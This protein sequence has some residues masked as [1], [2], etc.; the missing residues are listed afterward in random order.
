MLET[1]AIVEHLRKA[2]DSYESEGRLS[3]VKPF[4]GDSE[5]GD[6]P[7]HRAL[8][9]AFSYQFSLIQFT[10]ALLSVGIELEALEK[11]RRRFVW[12]RPVLHRIRF[13][14]GTGEYDEED[15]VETTSN[16]RNPDYVDVGKP[17]VLQHLARQT[18]DAFSWLRSESFLFALKAALVIAVSAIPSL[19]P[20]SAYFFYTNRGIWSVIVI[21][22]TL[23][24]YAGDTLF[25]VL[26]RIRGNLFGAVAGLIVWSIVS[27]TGIPHPA[28]LGFIT[29]ISFPLLLFYRIYALPA[30][31]TTLTCVTFVLVVG[32]SWQNVSIPAPSAIGYGFTVAW[33]RFVGISL[34]CAIAGVAS[35]FIPPVTLRKLTVRRSCAHAAAG[36][37][38]AIAETV[39]FAHSKRLERPPPSLL[40]N[41]IAGL[42]RKVAA[43]PAA[44]APIK[45]EP[46]WRGAWPFKQYGILH[47]LEMELLSLLSQFLSVVSSLDHEWTTILL[48]RVQLF[49][50][51]FLSRLLGAINAISTALEN[52]TPLPS[53]YDPLLPSLL[54]PGSTNPIDT[55][56]SQDTLQSLPYLTSSVGVSVMYAIVNRIDRL[57]LSTKEL[58]GEIFIVQ[59]VEAMGYSRGDQSSY[60][61]SRVS[62]DSTLH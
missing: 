49:D 22:L 7:S 31:R 12:S 50:P 55:H 27:G 40:V 51:A 35:A 41:R 37:G 9:W 8:Y 10:K 58:V 39:S 32:Y 24:G 34:G 30:V 62:L 53:L 43:L 19:L 2:I 17:T 4:A 1:T 38:E 21:A 44:I 25:G 46:S 52:G 16:S 42:R 61:H 26:G 6:A 48:R 20:A 56:V 57:M 14:R 29:L 59:G 13:S 15:F 60:A 3:V 18:S 33:R 36:I 11:K 5:T 47:K 45:F 23:T 28:L 54:L